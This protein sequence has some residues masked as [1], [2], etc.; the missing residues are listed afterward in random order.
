MLCIAHNHKWP[1]TRPCWS[2]M[3]ELASVLCRCIQSAWCWTPL[4]ASKWM[5]AGERRGDDNPAW[6]PPFVR[7]VWH[8]SSHSHVYPQSDNSISSG[9]SAGPIIHTPPHQ[10]PCSEASLR[11]SSAVS[12]PSEYSSSTEC[13]RMCFVRVPL[14]AKRRPHSSHP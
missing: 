5:A 12:T 4:T 8:I 2:S 14:C 7:H 13:M 1:V 11:Y 6:T 9:T 3:R 10:S